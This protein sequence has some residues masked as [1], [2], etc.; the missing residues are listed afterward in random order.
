MR[1]F[2]E[3]PM[4]KRGLRKLLL[5]S[6]AGLCVGALAGAA[7]AQSAQGG[8]ID[9]GQAELAPHGEFVDMRDVTRAPQIVIGH[10]GTPTTARD[11][12][13][14]TGVAQM[15]I[16]Q[17]NGFIGLCTAT[18]IN[19]R[20]VI[21]AAHCVNDRAGSAYGSGTGGTPIGFGFSNANLP[22]IIDWYLPG[23]GQHQTNTD[24]YFYNSNYVTYHPASLDPEAASFLYGDVAMASLDTVASDIPSWAMLF[25]ALPAPEIT[26]NGTGYHVDLAGYGNNGTGATGSSGGIDYRRRLAENM[27]GALASIDQ[28]ENFLFGGGGGLPQNLYW[29]DFDDPRRG[30]AQADIRDFNAWRDNPQ[31]NEGITA[32]GDSGGP[33][34]LD[35]EFDKPVVIGV[36]SGGYTRFFGGAPANGYGTASFYQPLYLYWDW[37]AANNPYRYVAALAGNGNWEDGAHWVSNLDPNYQIIGPDGE[38]VNGVPTELGEGPAGT[39]GSFGQACFEGPINGGNADC[40][41]MSTG[42]VTS[43]VR[44]IGTDGASDA[45]AV[46]SAGSLQNNAGVGSIADFEVGDAVRVAQNA[47]VGPAAQVNAAALPPAT[48]ANGLPGATGFVPNNT[49]GDRLADIAPRYF[50]VTLSA[51][52]TTTLSSDVTVDRLTMSGMGAGLNITG[53]G[54]LFSN[55]DITQLTGTLNVD[56][57]LGTSGDF[58]MM[59]GGLSGSGTITTPF[60]TNMAGVI[61]PGTP[62]QIGTL[63]FD[64]N[65]ILASGSTLLINL[66]SNGASDLISVTGQADLG[67]LVAFS[68]A[69]TPTYGQSYTFLTADGGL[70]GGF[71]SAPISAIL[72][73]EIVYGLNSVSVQIAAN[74]YADVVSEDSPI[75]QAFA[76]LLDQNRVLYDQFADFYVPLDALGAGGQSAPSAAP[77]TLSSSAIT[78][79]ALSPAE[80]VQQALENMAP[81]AETLRT[82]MGTA[83]LDGIGSFYRDRL[84][85]VEVG[86]LD[87]SFQVIGRPV[88]YA[89]AA[90]DSL[91]GGSISPVGDNETMV[92]PG[93]LPDNMRGFIAAGYMDGKGAPMAT[94]PGGGEDEFDGYF[95]ATGIEAA[96]DRQRVVGIALSTTDLSGSTAVLPQSADG[97]LWLATVYGHYQSD[98]GLTLNGQLSFGEFDTATQRLVTIGPDTF[99]LRTEDAVGVVAGEF[100]FGYRMAREQFNFTP[101]GSLRVSKMNYGTTKE[102]G[103][104]PALQYQ[105]DDTTSLESRLGFTV[106]GVSPTFRPWATANYVHSLNDATTAFGANFVGGVGPDAI[107]ALASDDKDWFEVGVGIEAIRDT[108]RLTVGAESTVGRDNVESQS[109]RAAVSFRF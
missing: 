82:A 94:A 53:A 1:V 100:G 66:G 58:F 44:P 88:D 86:D 43:E 5:T 25:S 109:Y 71:D 8:F 48:V 83:A 23:A 27:L 80:Q 108:W 29:I 75:Q 6:A 92:V 31:P 73:P 30:T 46:V 35:E 68:F 69:S 63:T 101:G 40:Q 70:T 103:A 77:A 24:N 32:S 13:N 47:Q 85:F 2:S 37:I 90:M 54:S 81:R 64:G 72:T 18:L 33:L 17:Q 60:F 62:S 49:D 104:G 21:F 97:Q 41:D 87:G 95:I 45:S 106:A 42:E 56:G 52:G 51:N 26:A 34:I 98:A 55:I 84:L 3:Q 11:P 91:D 96:I 7:Q 16:D 28:F 59:T 107:F 10:P 78:P 36:L 14:V 74:D 65:L 76:Q 15:I 102:S 22:G 4:M 93:A 20:T 50:D 57:H 38:L 12:V 105:R 99:T 67:G 9:G 61:A 39:D 79:L 19:P 89:S